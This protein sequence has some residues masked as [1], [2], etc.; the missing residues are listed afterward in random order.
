MSLRRVLP[1]FTLL[2]VAS[3][4]DKT[5]KDNHPEKTSLAGWA[6][7]AGICLLSHFIFCVLSFGENESE[8]AK[9]Q[10]TRPPLSFTSFLSSSL[11]L[12]L[13]TLSSYLYYRVLLEE[14][15]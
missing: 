2:L 3:S 15:T 11:C 8:K 7:A 10:I 9:T 12:L 6:V 1:V 14:D 4:E 13:T 5:L